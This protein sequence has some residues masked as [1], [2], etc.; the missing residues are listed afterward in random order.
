[1]SALHDKRKYFMKK[2]VKELS[3]KIQKPEKDLLSA[4]LSADDFGGKNVF[5]EYEDGSSS[6]FKYAF[7]VENETEYAIF[8]EHCDYHEFN[9]D[10][11]QQIQEE[12]SISVDK[13]TNIKWIG[14]GN[15]YVECEDKRLNL[16][17]MELISLKRE[18]DSF[19]RYYGEDF[20]PTQLKLFKNLT[21]NKH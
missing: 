6:F 1:M 14:D 15:A 16:N 3:K 13:L 5:I 12:D 9:K 7:Y 20:S 10:W 8:T 17:K 2:W 21:G 19:I 18:L 4:G 11:L